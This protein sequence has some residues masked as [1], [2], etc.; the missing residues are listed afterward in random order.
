MRDIDQVWAKQMFS[1]TG[2]DWKA[3]RAT[4]TP[5]FTS[6]K[7]KAMVG[8]IQSIVGRLMTDLTSRV[9][10][11]E[12]IELK[13]IMGNFSMDVIALCT[14]GSDAGYGTDLRIFPLVYFRFG[15]RSFEKGKTSPYVENA[16]GIFSRTPR[17]FIIGGLALF[18]GMRKLFGLL[19]VPI[20]KPKETR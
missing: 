20:F 12:M 5:I 8:M 18:P 4:F 17:E 9:E 14:F 3:V 19:G 10:A 7:L 13:D 11:G 1:L 16:R 2:E 6:G 15:F